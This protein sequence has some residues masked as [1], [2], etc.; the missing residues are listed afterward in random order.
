MTQVNPVYF[1]L[2]ILL[3]KNDVLN[4]FSQTAFLPI[5]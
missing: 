2:N 5:V 3:K 4:F 1:H